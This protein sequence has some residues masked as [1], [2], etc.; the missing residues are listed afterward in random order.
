M[1]VRCL[2]R[3]IRALTAVSSWSWWKLLCRARPLLD[4]NIDDQKFRAKEVS[5]RCC[6]A[7]VLC[8]ILPTMLSVCACVFSYATKGQGRLPEP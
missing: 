1:A 8:R 2:Q 4:V 3:N 6:D 5:M 7:A